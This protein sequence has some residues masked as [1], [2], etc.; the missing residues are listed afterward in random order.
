MVYARPREARKRC[1]WQFNIGIQAIVEEARKGCMEEAAKELEK[2]LK[3]TRAAIADG[4][5]VK[6]QVYI[7]PPEDYTSAYDLAIEQL[8]LCNERDV[9]LCGSEVRCLLLDQ[10]DWQDSFLAQTSAY[11]ETALRKLG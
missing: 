7:T 11:S 4:K 10:W 9:K 5:V 6:T 8:E 2:A 3:K 1:V